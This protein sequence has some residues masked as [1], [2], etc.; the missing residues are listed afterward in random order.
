MS[1]DKFSVR[2][3]SVMMDDVRKHVASYENVV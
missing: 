2:S 3:G 1:D